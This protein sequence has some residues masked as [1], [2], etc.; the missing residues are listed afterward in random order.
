MGVSG[1][2]G[3]RNLSGLD[4]SLDFPEE[5]FASARL[6][7]KITLVNRRKILP[8]FLIRITL[9]NKEVLFPFLPPQGVA[10]RYADFFFPRRGI[11][12]I[13]MIYLSSVYPFNFFT[14]FRAIAGTYET[15]VFP[16]IKKCEPPG[17]NPNRTVRAGERDLDKS[18]SGGEMVS[19]RN[20]TAGDP[21]RFIHWKSSAK[22]GEL[23]TKEFSATSSRPVVIDF[24]RVDMRDEEEKI[25][26]I[27]YL[28][29]KSCRNNIP[30]GLRINEIFY[31][32][33]LS[34]SHK[35]RMLRELALYGDHAAADTN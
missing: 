32:P 18:G 22:T 6:P 2:F 19:V 29:V 26:C 33:G 17:L 23:K 3:K 10:S 9:D 12:G 25:S 11:Y 15:I 30:V 8:A 28:I 4:I 16:Q 20:Y 14:R 31:K 34:K 35:T 21:S 7:V 5:I 24:E 13:R 1:F 27:T